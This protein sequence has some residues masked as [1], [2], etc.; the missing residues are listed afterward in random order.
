MTLLD[1]CKIT[2]FPFPGRAEATRLALTIGSV[3]FT[4][5]RITFPQ[6]KE[7]KETTTWGCLPV[8]T[9]SDGSTCISQQR[10]IL[11][12]VGKETN[13]YPTDS[14][15]AA[16]VDELMDA[17][18]DLSG[19]TFPIGAGLPQAEKEAARKEACETGGATY[20]ILEKLEKFI[21]ENGTNGHAV[22]ENLTV[23]DLFLY[24]TSSHLVSGIFDGVPADT[25]DAFPIIQA[26]RKVVRSHPV[27][28]KFYD[29]LDVKI[30]ESYGPL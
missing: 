22:G 3:K 29:E 13:L 7:I 26:C 10:A 21:S 11:R 20:G 25:L 14:I 5:D 2:Y 1:G 9:L 18:E 4:D 12:F 15:A 30:A 28:T 16:K 17:L 19:K 8:L 6:W 27:V 23:A 24:A